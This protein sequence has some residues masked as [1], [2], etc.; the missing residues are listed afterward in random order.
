MKKIEFRN[1]YTCL[2]CRTNRNKPEIYMPSFRFKNSIQLKLK[3]N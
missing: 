3:L 1:F 2:S